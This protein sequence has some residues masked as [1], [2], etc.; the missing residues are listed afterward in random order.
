MTEQE[1]EKVTTFR[2]DFSQTTK[3]MREIEIEDLLKAAIYA[4][5][6]VMNPGHKEPDDYTRLAC[7]QYRANIAL[8]KIKASEEGRALLDSCLAAPGKNPPVS[9]ESAQASA[10]MTP[11]QES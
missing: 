6:W 1:K 3:T 7:A 5:N 10:S 9:G 4:L 2:P 8:E 11:T